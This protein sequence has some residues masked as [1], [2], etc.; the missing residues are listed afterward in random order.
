MI[1]TGA[2]FAL[3]VLAASKV[4][5]YAAGGALALWAVALA[6]FG[7]TRPGFPRS[8]AGRRGV[9]GASLLLVA[10]AMSLA[11][12]TA[13][14]EGG[15]EAA[16]TSTSLDLATDPSGA[17]A[18]DR[19]EGTLKAGE[20]TIHLTNDSTQDHNVAVADGD[21][22]LGRSD[23][24]KEAETDLRLDLQPGEYAFYC[25][26]DAHRASGMEGTLTV[27]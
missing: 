23:T 22:V 21:R 24:V 12:A 3:S 2:A 18:Y 13:G 4:P 8:N 17:A 16:A 10:T 6:A 9:I 20:V 27:R 1:P 5:F 19:K 14:E 25:T 26:V 7:I 11:V 15:E